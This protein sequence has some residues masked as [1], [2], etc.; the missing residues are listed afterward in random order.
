M[1]DVF[2]ELP[3]IIVDQRVRTLKDAYYLRPDLI[4]HKNSLIV[5]SHKKNPMRIKNIYK[6][7]DLARTR[8]LL[9]WELVSNSKVKVQL[10]VNKIETYKGTFSLL[11]N[12]SCRM[13]HHWV[14]DVL[15]TLESEDL[16]ANQRFIINR[17]LTSWKKQSL[18]VLGVKKLFPIRHK[19]IMF[20]ERLK[21]C[22]SAS[23]SNYVY[24]K[25]INWLVEHLVPNKL[26]NTFFDKIF[27]SRGDIS[28][29]PRN[30]N[31]RPYVKSMVLKY[32]YKEIFCSQYSFKEQIQLFANAKKIVIEHGSAGAN[33]I[34]C[35]VGCHILYLQPDLA[36]GFN[37]HVLASRLRGHNIGLLFGLSEKNT[38]SSKPHNVPWSVD[39]NK[40]EEA[41]KIMESAY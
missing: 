13:Y 3:E 37:Q 2:K 6:A 23:E 27:V 5:S 8:D 28:N 10:N 17:P 24:G 19:Q 38:K 11:A 21:F 15:P 26:E 41:L 39:I 1:I 30:L 25:G 34:F 40:L 14:F 32:G 12:S 20:F 29:H 35:P 33:C 22:R 16:D 31:N 36:N 18:D 4:F 7:L 9:N